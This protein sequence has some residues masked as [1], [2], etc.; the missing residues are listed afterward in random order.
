[1]YIANSL[2]Y[3]LGVILH[4]VTFS[5]IALEHL[6]VVTKRPAFVPTK[7]IELTKWLTTKASA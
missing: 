6:R 7:T 5:A 1:M 3:V 2:H 4:R